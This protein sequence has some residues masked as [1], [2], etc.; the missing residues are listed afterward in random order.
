MDAVLDRVE[1]RGEARVNE[2]GTRMLAAGCEKHFSEV[3]ILENSNYGGGIGEEGG[4]H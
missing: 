4:W 1:A 3:M 2:L